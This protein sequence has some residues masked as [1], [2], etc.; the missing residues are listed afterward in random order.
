MYILRLDLHINN[1]DILAYKWM[2][3]GMI[4]YTSRTITRPNNCLQIYWNTTLY[5]NYIII[6]ANSIIILRSTCQRI[7]IYI[8]ICI[9][10]IW[11]I[12]YIRNIIQA[13]IH[14]TRQLTLTSRQASR[15]RAAGRPNYTDTKL[16]PPVP[17]TRSS[18]FTPSCPSGWAGIIWTLRAVRLQSI[19]GQRSRRDGFYSWRGSEKKE[20]GIMCCYLF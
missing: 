11:G 10:C 5:P 7:Y 20:G 19:N 2:D 17:P 9:Q 4:I 18:A 16:S 6:L 1:W 13:S 12:K 8:Y 3:V 15:V 14:A